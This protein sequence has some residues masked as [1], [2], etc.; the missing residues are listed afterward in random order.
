MSFSVD[1]S[2]LTVTIS[3]CEKMNGEFL[4]KLK[5]ALLNAEQSKPDNVF[6]KP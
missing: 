4:G 5:A 2:S 6:L 3:F 1:L